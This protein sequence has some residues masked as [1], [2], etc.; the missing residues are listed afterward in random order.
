MEQKINVHVCRHVAGLAARMRDIFFPGLARKSIHC[1]AP[2]WNTVNPKSQLLRRGSDSAFAAQ[3]TVIEQVEMSSRFLTNYLIKSFCKQISLTRQRYFSAAV[4]VRA[5]A[6][7]QAAFFEDAQ[8]AKAT[9]QITSTHANGAKRRM[10]RFA[11]T[12]SRVLPSF[13]AS[14]S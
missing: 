8:V 9:C 6:L 1:S 4:F 2:I 11:L 13:S 7:K 5:D 14:S 3:S 10:R 12:V